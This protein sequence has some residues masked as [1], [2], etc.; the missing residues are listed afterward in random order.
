MTLQHTTIFLPC[1]SLHDFPTFLHGSEADSLLAT[2]TTAWHPELIASTKGIPTWQRA[3]DPPEPEPLAGELLLVPE[4]AHS[5]LPPNWLN[6]F[7]ATYPVNPSPIVEMK[8]RSQIMGALS[9]AGLVHDDAIDGELVREFFGLGYCY[10]QVELLTHA[11]QYHNIIEP[12]ELSQATVTAAEAAVCGDTHQARNQL[13]RAFD[14]LT[15]ARQHSYPVDPYFIDVRL[16][17]PGIN[18]Q[19]LYD[20]LASGHP[21]NLLVSGSEIEQIAKQSPQVLTRLKQSIS[22]GST[23]VVGGPYSRGNLENLSPE[24]LLAEFFHGKAAYRTTLDSDVTIFGQFACST[25]P[26]L[27]QVL[28]QLQFRGAML[29]TFDGTRKPPSEQAKTRWQEAGN[30]VV[31]ALSVTP[32]DF[33]FSHVTRPFFRSR[34]VTYMNEK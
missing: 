2:W 21:L 4:T 27:P 10:L 8:T 32:Q 24:H 11:M 20:C 25:S 15:Q 29:S 18:D 22:A 31:D 5:E 13:E 16:F 28:Q 23:S 17:S 14:L 19:A 26:L 34:H 33:Y 7:R 1:H 6:R 3:D 30:C 9:E 12:Q